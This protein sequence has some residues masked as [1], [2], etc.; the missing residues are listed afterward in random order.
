MREAILVTV[1]VL[2][3]SV[4]CYVAYARTRKWPWLLPAV[5]LLVAASVLLFG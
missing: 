3:G 5:L 1:L 2:S 4:V